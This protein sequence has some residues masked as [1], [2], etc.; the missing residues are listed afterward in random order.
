MAAVWKFAPGKA[1]RLRQMPP[2][3]GRTLSR[4]EFSS[5]RRIYS[6]QV[7]KNKR[8]ILN[9]R[10]VGDR[11]PS[12]TPVSQPAQITSPARLNSVETGPFLRPVHCADRFD[13]NSRT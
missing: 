1:A 7:L 12:I 10:T 4:K 2:V 6:R 13:A 9:D 8:R 3:Q 11:R 5:V